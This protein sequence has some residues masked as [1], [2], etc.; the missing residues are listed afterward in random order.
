MLSN[1][2]CICF[3]TLEALSWSMQKILKTPAFSHA[4]VSWAF[5]IACAYAHTSIQDFAA[6]IRYKGS[7]LSRLSIFLWRVA[8]YSGSCFI[9]VN[10]L[11]WSSW[12]D[13]ICYCLKAYVQVF[14][15][16]RIF[17]SFFHTSE[18]R[19]LHRQKVHFIRDRQAFLHSEHQ[20]QW[21]EERRVD[22]PRR[23]SRKCWIKPGRS[24]ERERERVC[25]VY[26][27]T[28]LHIFVCLQ[29]PTC[30]LLSRAT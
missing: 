19:R 20:G 23:R 10:F 26:A 6:T 22:Y 12:E 3:K 1:I 28:A 11:S 25:G 17:S 4:A 30:K 8:R 16:L 7:N 13:A 9:L 18:N 14:H 21:E 15:L 2:F 27:T 24:Y 5:K 29:T